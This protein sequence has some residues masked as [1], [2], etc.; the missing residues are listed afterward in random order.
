MKNLRQ[1]CAA[2]ALTLILALS[3]GAGEISF[4]GVID[5]PP[6]PPQSSMTGDMGAGGITATGDMSVPGAAALDPV[7]EAALS[8]L[9][10]LLSLF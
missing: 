3:T 1:F 9:R 6:P 7:T 5:P 2:C 10:S 4:P 8:V